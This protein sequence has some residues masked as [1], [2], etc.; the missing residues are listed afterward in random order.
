MFQNLHVIIINTVIILSTPD[1]SG[2]VLA[3]RNVE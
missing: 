1:E 3:A 2:T